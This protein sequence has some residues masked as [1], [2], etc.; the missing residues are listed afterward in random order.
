MAKQDETPR[1]HTFYSD[2]QLAKRYGVHRATLW[3]WVQRHG[4]PAPIKLSPGCARWRA[5]DIEEYERQAK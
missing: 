2:L 1:E 3:R 4:F 5:S